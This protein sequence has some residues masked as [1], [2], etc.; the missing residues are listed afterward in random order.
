MGGGPGR[1]DEG[2][3]CGAGGTGRDGFVVNVTLA[4]AAA[5]DVFGAAGFVRRSGGYIRYNST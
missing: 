2:M 5:G 4:T 1:D 3:A